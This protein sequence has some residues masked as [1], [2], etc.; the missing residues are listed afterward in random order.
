MLLTIRVVGAVLATF[1][2]A[3]SRA[4]Q[5]RASRPARQWQAQLFR[6]FCMVCLVDVVE[7]TTSGH[8][9][10]GTKKNIKS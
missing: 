1:L 10:L 4:V 2:A 8:L 7:N 5:T 9:H 6:D 3:R